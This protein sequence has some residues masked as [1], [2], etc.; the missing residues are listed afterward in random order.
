[1]VE[2]LKKPVEAVGEKV[3]PFHALEKEAKLDPV[4]HAEVLAALKEL[5]DKNPEIKKVLDEAAGYAVIPSIG[6]A[7]LVLGGLR[8]RRG[9]RA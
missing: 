2:A 6:R 1:M 8:S 5:L 7:S 9:V 3:A 4:L